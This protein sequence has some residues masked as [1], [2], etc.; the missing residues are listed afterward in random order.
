MFFFSTLGA[1]AGI[2]VIGSVGV[3]FY[4]SSRGELWIEFLNGNL[5]FFPEE[6]ADLRENPGG[7]GG[8]R[9][10]SS[11]GGGRCLTETIQ[12]VHGL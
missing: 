9:M 3:F 4:S 12:H 5:I 8:G 7:G 6:S 1:E 2:L 11:M 10:P